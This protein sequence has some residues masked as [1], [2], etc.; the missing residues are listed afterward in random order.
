MNLKIDKELM[1]L[2][3]LD[4]L[5]LKWL[6]KQTKQERRVQSKVDREKILG[7]LGRKCQICGFDDVVEI[8]HIQ[9]A[10]KGGNEDLSNLAVLCPN[11]HRMV[12]IPQFR[13]SVSELLENGKQ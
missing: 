13:R 11:H 9:P 4:E 6:I 12:H 5:R 1:K 3:N 7:I 10:S 8:H 2:L